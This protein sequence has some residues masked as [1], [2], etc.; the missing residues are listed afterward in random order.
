[1]KFKV[2]FRYFVS[3]IFNHC[4]ATDYMQY[5]I[6]LKANSD[7][8]IETSSIPENW[9]SKCWKKFRLI[10]LASQLLRCCMI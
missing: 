9:V 10:F 3:G 7:D 6:F 8:N 5:V 4:K 2:A 1:M